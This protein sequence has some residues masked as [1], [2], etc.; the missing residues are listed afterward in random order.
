ME[1]WAA[2]RRRWPLAAVPVALGLQAV[3]LSPLLL[4]VLS[5]AAMARSALPATRK[6]FAD[7]IGWPDL[8][9]QVGAVYR[10]LPPDERRSAVII[11]DNV[12]IAGAVDT[13]G[14]AQG[15]PGAYSPQLSGWYWLPPHLE[16]AAVVLAGFSP[17]EVSNLCGDPT[18]AGQI[19]NRYGLRN[20]TDGQPIY[21]CHRLRRPLDQLWPK[22]KRFA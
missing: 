8:V 21:V 5:E 4:P 11:G 1:G 14:L 20:L 10:G 16:P 12:G 19:H 3:L 13:F 9:Q 15:L 18:P 2:G 7:T 17:E 22:M 6:D